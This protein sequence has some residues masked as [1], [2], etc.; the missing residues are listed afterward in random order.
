METISE[1]EHEACATSHRPNELSPLHD[2][3]GT[4]QTTSTMGAGTK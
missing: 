4:K 2:D 3:E 1:E